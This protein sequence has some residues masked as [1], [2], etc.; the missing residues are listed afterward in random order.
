MFRR[1]PKTS[2]QPGLEP[3]DSTFRYM[4][5]AIHL[6]IEGELKCVFAGGSTGIGKSETALRLIHTHSERLRRVW[7]AKSD[8]DKDEDD[9]VPP[10]M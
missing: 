2:N 9:F 3:V 1:M 7:E 5:D 10:I 6:L 8:E 4:E